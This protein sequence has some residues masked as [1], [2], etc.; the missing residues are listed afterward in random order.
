M[1]SAFL[2]LFGATCGYGISPITGLYCV[3]QEANT[4][5]PFGDNYMLFTVG[6]IVC[7]F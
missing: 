7:F 3:Y 6:Y 5:S 2:N 4:N 1:D